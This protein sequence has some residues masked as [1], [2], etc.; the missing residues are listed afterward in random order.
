MKLT[1]NFPQLSISQRLFGYFSAIFLL[2]FTLSTLIELLLINTLLTLPAKLQ[3]E[4]QD[5]AYQAQAYIDNNDLASLK[6]WEEAQRYALYVV[7]NENKSITAREIHPHAQFKMSQSRQLDQPMNN[8][9]SKPMLAIHLSNDDHLMIQLPWQLHPAD[10]AKY[11]LWLMRFLVAAITLAL[12]SRIFAKHLQQPLRRLQKVSRQLATGNLAVR[13]SN[14]VNS[15]ITEFH[16]L[17]LDFDHMA[18]QIE[19]LLGSHK[20]LLRNISHEL[21]TPLT[22]QS[23]AMHLLKSRLHPEQ[24]SYFETIEENSEEMN[25][26]IQ[27]ILDFSRLQS[28]HFQFELS[29]QQLAPIIEQAIEKLKPELGQQQRIS[30]VNHTEDSYV[31]ADDDAITCILQN[32]ISNALKYAGKKCTVEI[33]L[34]R[35]K[36]D[37]IL[38]I[39][40]NGPGIEEQHLHKIFEPFYRVDSS[41]SKAIEGYGLGMAIMKQNIEQMNGTIS[42]ESPSGKGLTIR[43][44]LP[45]APTTFSGSRT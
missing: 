10:E 41:R 19:K 25:R 2:V 23:L 40:D 5:L 34:E 28:R 20:K 17:A 30:F 1:Q 37:I 12:V 24:L 14:Q 4:F 29:P 27:Q 16:N 35:E 8:R 18:S 26:L 32:A 11:Y 44:Q 31:M 42:V 43:C 15:N 7:D 45:I 22:R 36:R 6:N 3:Q 33:N 21:R 39:S 9:V 13:A 38:I